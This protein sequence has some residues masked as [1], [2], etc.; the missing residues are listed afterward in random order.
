[1]DYNKLNCEPFSEE[2]AKMILSTRIRVAR[3]LAD[4]PLGTGISRE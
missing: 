3:N 4:F 2:D 1:M